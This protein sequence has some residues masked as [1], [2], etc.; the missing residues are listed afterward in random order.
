[1]YRFHQ[2]NFC[3]YNQAF[4]ALGCVIRTV[5]LLQYVA[6]AHLREVITETTNKAEQF[7]AFCKWLF[8]GGEGRITDQTPEEQEKR[9]KYN[10]LLANAVVLHNTLELSRVLAELAKEGYHFTREEVA[11]L[12]PYQTQH[13]KRFGNYVID[14]ES[15]PQLVEEDIPLLEE[16]KW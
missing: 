1:L 8:F 9:I 12:S 5:F 10:T 3:I 16:R 6:D 13:I 2:L 4:R 15:L 7:H 14:W 11:L